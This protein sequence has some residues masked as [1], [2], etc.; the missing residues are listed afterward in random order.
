MVGLYPSKDIPSDGFHALDRLVVSVVA[1]VRISAAEIEKLL[2]ILDDVA[3]LRVHAFL[4]HIALAS[5]LQRDM[6]IV[7]DLAP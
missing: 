2:L 7:V 5:S 1:D 6:V 4:P 3:D